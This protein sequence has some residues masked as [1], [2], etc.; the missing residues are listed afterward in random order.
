MG[1]NIVYYRKFN[2]KRNENKKKKIPER[3]QLRVGK[4]IYFKFL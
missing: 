3:T 1:R 4:Y 2:L